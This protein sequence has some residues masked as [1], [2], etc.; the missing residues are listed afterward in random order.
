VDTQATRDPGGAEDGPDPR[1]P[2]DGRYWARNSEDD[3]PLLA[4][5]GDFVGLLQAIV[6]SR[7]AEPEGSL[8]TLFD[9]VD[10][11]IWDK[12]A[13]EASPSPVGVAQLLRWVADLLE[14]EWFS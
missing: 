13:P 10:G 9:S 14:R 6:R 12:G 5:E 3:D 1:D 2:G 8:S 7:A 11:Q 4:T